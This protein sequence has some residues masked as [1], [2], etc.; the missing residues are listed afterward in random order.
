M[1]WTEEQKK[2][3]NGR[4]CNLLVSAAAGSGKTAVL[5]ERIIN[6]VLDKENPVDIDK[7]VVVTF[8][9]AAAEEMKGRMVDA[10]EKILKDNPDDVRLAKQIA[11][12]GHAKISTID[13]FCSY[14]L[15]NY[16]NS[17]GFDP[18]FRVAD[19]GELALLK[20][21]VYDD[22]IEEYFR[23]GNENFINVVEKYAPGKN[24]NKLADIIKSL[25]EFSESHPWQEEWIMECRSLYEINNEE[26]FNESSLVKFFLGYVKDLCR[27]SV[28]TYDEL[29]EFCGENAELQPYIE[30]LESDRLILCK[31]AECSSY[32]EMGDIL[33]VRF[34]NLKQIRN[35]SDP[36]SKQHVQDIRNGIKDRIKTLR[37]SCF[38]NTDGVI[39]SVKNCRSDMEMI[40]ELTLEFAGRY[41]K[42]KEERNIVTF[43]DIE[44]KA[45]EILIDRT[46][47]GERYTTVADELAG[48]FEEIYIDEYQDSNYVQ[49][50]ILN[51][52]SRCRFGTP[53]I[54]MVGDVKQSI[55]KFRM[56]KPELF[57]EKYNTYS[58]IDT[59]SKY[60]KVELHSNFRSA[61]NVINT[62]NDI[63]Y[64]IMHKSVGGIEYNEENALY[65]GGQI[66]DRIDTTTNFCLIPEQVIKDYGIEKQEAYA[67]MAALRIKEMMAEDSSLRYKDFAILLRSDKK[68]GL[69]YADALNIQGIPA[70]YSSTVGYFSAYEIRVIMDV[71]RVIDN[72]RQEIPLAGMMRSYFGYFTTDDMALVK[73]KKRKIDLYECVM[74]YADKADELGKKCRK[75]IDFIDEYRKKSGLMTIRELVTELIYKSGF[76]DYAGLMPSGNTRKMN[77]DMMILKAREFEKTS[78]SGLF[79]FIRYMDKIKKYEIDYSESSELESNDN[80]VRIMSIHQSKGLQFPVVI[81]GDASKA[82]NMLDMNEAVVIDSTY[83]IGMDEIDLEKRVKRK[84][85]LKEMI[86]RKIESDNIGEE[87][88]ILYVALTRAVNKL[89]V[90][91]VPT[92]KD[93]ESIVNGS[94]IG[95]PDMEYI[96]SHKNYAMLI[97][98][99]LK[100]DKCKGQY[101]IREISLEELINVAGS[102]LEEKLDEFSDFFAVLSEYDD[103]EQF[104]EV[105]KILDYRYPFVSIKGLKSKYSVSEIKHM[106]MEE[107]ER[108]EA[109]VVEPEKIRPVPAFIQK[110]EEVT[111]TLRGTAY[112]KFF[113]I[114]DYRTCRDYESI[115]AYLR[116]CI[117]SG[118]MSEE[119][120][121]LINMKVFITFIHSEL[122]KRMAAA[123]SKGLLYREQ[124]FIMEIP[125][126]RVNK[127]FPSDEKVLIQGIVDAFFFENDKVYIV[128]YKTDRVNNEKDLVDRYKKQL[129]LYAET[130][131]SVTG[132]EMGAC[133]LYSTCLGK[134]III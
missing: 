115:E 3:I 83:G 28:R 9:K 10:F 41:A 29:I 93:Y 79:N 101:N 120:G 91:S 124:P 17:I 89:I 63:F 92:G 85:V 107:N 77:L 100:S 133:Y 7:I 53:N 68:S 61:V 125:A 111:G 50:K 128:D 55:Y 131:V 52:V 109:M 20:A 127:E 84:F 118:I 80:Y 49:E 4:N 90:L 119:Y 81:L 98:T 126:D 71:L 14:I 86:R 76:Y 94:G 129:E 105:Q 88:R 69:H 67:Y 37:E 11:L 130:L 59:D 70:V 58:D 31:A 112:H 56:A 13:S 43:S 1:A 5:V 39:E 2:A 106:A 8:T 32:F 72:P 102:N 44:H 16:Y 36:E 73:G 116:N 114:F 87:L 19:A 64:K 60:R 30:T 110:S 121:K 66:E 22:M 33:S 113:E 51:A 42:A 23:Q 48:I 35:C 54:F 57:I 18:A 74:Q 96:L 24:I 40:T 6:R 108:P 97:A 26:E 34:S 99:A 46:E 122:G 82:Y 75:L 38:V 132:R 123:D 117:E 27:E 45:L 25:Q 47:N 134:E 78:Y 103:E 12:T 15:R 62:V 95:E 65:Y 104:N 21:D